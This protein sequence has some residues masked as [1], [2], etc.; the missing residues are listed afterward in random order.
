MRRAA[1]WWR[2][3]RE[4]RHWIAEAL[5]TT[6]LREEPDSSGYPLMRRTG[7]SSGRLYVALARLEA[8]G[9]ITARWADGPYPRRRLYRLAEKEG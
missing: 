5:I 9:R 2:A 8:A 3:R 6:A 4:R 1:Q 7:L